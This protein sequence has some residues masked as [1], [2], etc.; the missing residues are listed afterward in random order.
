MCVCGV[1]PLVI[2][3]SNGKYTIYRYVYLILQV[4]DNSIIHIYIFISLPPLITR[5]YSGI[6]RQIDLQC[7]QAFCW[8]I[9]GGKV[10]DLLTMGSHGRFLDGLPVQMVIFYSEL[11]NYQ[12][13]FEIVS[14]FLTFYLTAFPI[15]SCER[16][17]VSNAGGKPPPFAG[18]G[19]D[20]G[21]CLATM[22]IHMGEWMSYFL[23]FG[24][25]LNFV[26][27]NMIQQIL[28]FRT[29][30]MRLSWNLD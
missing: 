2:K 5:G 16:R 4:N 6:L 15:A 3:R 17:N 11:L 30:N 21:T 7:I 29:W 10:Y 20:D 28:G 8:H 18:R 19:W 23:C 24:R 13:V 14:D 1:S 22:M 25:I 9:L 27:S 26:R 12:R